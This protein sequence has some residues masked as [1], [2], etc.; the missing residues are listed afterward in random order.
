MTTKI[1]ATIKDM[2]WTLGSRYIVA[3]CKAPDDKATPALASRVA[4][5][6]NVRSATLQAFSW[7]QMQKVIGKM[8]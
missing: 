4:S 2:C 1:G 8:V 5:R 3:V 6:G 7:S